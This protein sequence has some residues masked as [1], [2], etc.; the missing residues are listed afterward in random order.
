MWKIPSEENSTRWFDKLWF[1]SLRCTN[2]WLRELRHDHFSAVWTHASHVQVEW[3]EGFENVGSTCVDIE[4][5]R[6]SV[7]RQLGVK[8]SWRIGRNKVLDFVRRAFAVERNVNDVLSHRETLR[9]LGAMSHH[10]CRSNMQIESVA[11]FSIIV[12]RQALIKPFIFR[13]NRFNFHDGIFKI[14]DVIVGNF[15]AIFVPS[16]QSF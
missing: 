11:N 2:D 7:H 4:T 1:D 13:I 16:Q 3:F 14:F 5:F 15:L 10:D 6:V 9:I 12:P 8:V